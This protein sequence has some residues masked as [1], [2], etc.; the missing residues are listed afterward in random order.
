MEE[1]LKDIGRTI[2]CMGMENMSG[3]MGENMRV[4]F[5]FNFRGVL[6]G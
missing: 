1:C 4:D 2:I 3:G 5:P 6:Y